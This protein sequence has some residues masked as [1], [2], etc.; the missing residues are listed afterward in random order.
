[1]ADKEGFFLE[2]LLHSVQ[3]PHDILEEKIYMV[4]LITKYNPFQINDRK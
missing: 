4:T 1:M 2:L 3:Y